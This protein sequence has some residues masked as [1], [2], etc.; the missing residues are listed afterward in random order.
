MSDTTG[1]TDIKGPG[2]TSLIV[3]RSSDFGTPDFRIFTVDAGV[4]AKLDGLTITGGLAD[5]GGG[6][7]N[8][9]NLKVTGCIVSENHSFSV[10]TGSGGGILDKGGSLTIDTSTIC[11]NTAYHGGGIS[12]VSGAVTITGSTIRDNTAVA[13]GGIYC[14]SDLTL[15]RV[16]VTNNLAQGSDGADS[17]GATVR[18]RKGVASTAGAACCRSSTTRR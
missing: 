1:L 17:G 6:I 14:Q 18:M 4:T 3:A 9:G 12:I 7:W 13:G 8:Q 10:E 11:G 16:M 15:S 2:A 5:Q